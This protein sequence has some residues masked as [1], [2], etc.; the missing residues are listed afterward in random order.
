MEDSSKSNRNKELQHKQE[1][2]KVYLPNTIRTGC[3]PIQK[4]KSDMLT[5]SGT[6]EK[7]EPYL[8]ALLQGLWL[9]ANVCT[10]DD[11][12]EGTIQ[13]RET[14]KRQDLGRGESS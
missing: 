2:A 10:K 14:K 13:K 8:Q 4:K 1:G 12:W 6:E 9:L 3:P 7:L 11:H 5:R